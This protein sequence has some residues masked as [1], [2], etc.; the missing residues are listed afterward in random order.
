MDAERFIGAEKVV[1]P[2]AERLKN[3]FEV[4]KKSGLSCQTTLM[5][6]PASTAMRGLK[7]EAGLLERLLCAENVAPPSEERPNKILEFVSVSSSQTT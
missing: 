3:T 6:P 5:L 4:L 7:E 1:P 2:S